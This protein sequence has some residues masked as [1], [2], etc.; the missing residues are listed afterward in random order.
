MPEQ[1]RLRDL[2]AGHE[3][4]DIVVLAEKTAQIAARKEDRS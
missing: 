3:V 4:A 2:L 1:L